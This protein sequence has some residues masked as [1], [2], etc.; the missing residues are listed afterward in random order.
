LARPLQHGYQEFTFGTGNAAQ[1]YAMLVNDINDLSQAESHILHPGTRALYRYWETIRAENAAPEHNVLQLKPIASLIPNLMMLERD[2]LRQSYKWRLAGG[3]ICGLFRRPLTGS[4]AL[5][6]WD[7]F[8]SDTISKLFDGVVT[9]LQ[10]C[11][12]RFRLTTDRGQSLG[13][14]LIGLPLHAQNGARFHI[15]GGIFPFQEMTNF[16]YDS[17]TQMELSAARS[18]WTEHLPGDKLVAGLRNN[19]NG[20]ADL[21]VIPGG[22]A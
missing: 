19:F 12:I 5:S 15:F 6:G 20:K 3:Q 18:I 21:R 9:V 13:A 8:E 11:L 16:N 1:G 22:R 17:V 4:D 14:E 2:N 7:K 10:P